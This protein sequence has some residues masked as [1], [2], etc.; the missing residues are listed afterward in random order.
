MTETTSSPAAASATPPLDARQERVLLV[1]LAGIQFCHIVDFMVMMPLGPILL[2]E[3][4]IAAHEFGLLVS[5]YT[6]TAAIA[7]VLV[8]GFV[9]RFERKRLLLLTFA[10]F[11][12]ATLACGLAPD[13][14]TLLFA[15]CAAGAFGGVLGAMVHTMVGDLIPYERRGRA[16]GT[17]MAAF[18]AST[19]A[20]VPLSLFLA[21][22]FGW[23]APFVFIALLTLGFLALGWA[24]LPELRGHLAEADSAVRHRAR[25]LA[26]MGRVVGD[27]NARNALVFMALVI[28]S[29]F[30]IIPFI[31]IYLV[32]NVGISQAQV[33]LIY[34]FGGLASFFS[35]RWIGRLAD[36]HGKRRVYRFVAFG[37]LLPLLAVTHLPPVPIAVV[38]IVTTAFFVLV[39]G[40]MV[41][42][43]AIVTAAVRPELRG[44]FMSLAA[45]MQQLASGAAAFIG[46]L[47]VT[48][49]DDGRLLRYNLAGYVALAITLPA[50]YAVRRIEIR[51]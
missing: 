32:S 45:S 25:P 38:L 27:R 10:L 20:G 6:F 49:G 1:T 50:I 4:S 15:R 44:T 46:G 12:I 11:A 51:N 31:T 21:N 34:L 14:A 28:A 47:I 5:A 8:A 48:T 41:P 22:H 29:G 39:P 36:R 17:V 13:F 26:A 43:V 7:G 24:K 33:P 37:A 35:S 42:A 19:V 30:T 40:R 2:Q 16:S 23:R 9:D 3:L 18:S